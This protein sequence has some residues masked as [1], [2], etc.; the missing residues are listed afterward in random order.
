VEIRHFK[1]P[2]FSFLQTDNWGKDG[3]R[4]ALLFSSA[5]DTKKRSEAGWYRRPHMLRA[6]SAGVCQAV[7][8]EAN[9]KK[10]PTREK[11]QKGLKGQAA[12]F[13]VRAAPAQSLGNR[14]A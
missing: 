4:P 14:E 2:G 1:K 11:D 5:R 8:T 13:T 9:R 3:T 12:K 7:F 6:T 10:L